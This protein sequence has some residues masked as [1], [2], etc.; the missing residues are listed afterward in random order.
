MKKMLLL[1]TTIFF[2]IVIVIPVVFVMALQGDEEKQADEQSPSLTQSDKVIDPKEIE[3]QIMISVY[4]TQMKKVEQIPIEE[5][6][7]GVVAAEMP[8]D[9]EQEA[10]KAQA[11]AARTYIIRRLAEKDFSDVPAEGVVTDTVQHQVFLDDAQRRE[12]WGGDYEWKT[13]KIREAVVATTGQVITYNGKPINATFFS[14][15]NGYTENSEEY[16]QQ[17]IPYLRSV[18]V[19]WDRESPLYQQVTTLS[20]ETFRKKLGVPLTV[21]ASTG[22]AWSQVLDRSTGKRIARIKVGDRVF[23][24]REIREKLN[25]PSSHFSW[26]IENGMVIITT[27]GYGHGVGMS[28][29]GANGMARDGKTVEEI[30]SYFYRG[31]EIEDYHQWVK[32]VAYIPNHTKNYAKN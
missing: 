27:F 31:V 1:F 2:L 24:G 29:W 20:V 10:L 17:E 26:K 6:V 22:S 21:E 30:I 23:T 8:A 15:S 9:F 19:P 14:T 18:E 25:L 12:K 32:Q 13:R 4:R 7:E 16:W 3:D 11:I 28:Q 5:Y